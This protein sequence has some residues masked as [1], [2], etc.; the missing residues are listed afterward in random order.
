MTRP[1]KAKALLLSALLLAAVPVVSS[2]A[3]EM[4][5]AGERVQ[6]APA[7]PEEAS[8]SPLL[9]ATEHA[10]LLRSDPARRG[11]GEAETALFLVGAAI[12]IVF[13]VS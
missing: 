8:A 13:L 12:L 3:A 4:P 11:G 6:A 1:M 7:P 10:E 2:R 5:A 9:D